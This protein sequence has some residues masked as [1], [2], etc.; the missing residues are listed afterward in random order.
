MPDGLAVASL[1]AVVAVLAGTA[2]ALSVVAALAPSGR[3][4]PSP[5]SAA[6]AAAGSIGILALGVIALAGGV[7][8]TASFGTVLGFPLVAVR[9]DALG[10]LFMIPLGIVGAAASV[11][12]IGYAAHGHPPDRTAAAYPVFLASLALVFASSDLIA[13]LLAWE[14]MAL[15]SAALVFGARPTADVA[16]AGY[17]YLALTHLAAGAVIVAFAMLAGAAGST[18][19]GSLGAAAASLPP[20]A[21]D[22][23]FVLLLVGFGTKAGA[24]P[25]HVWLPRAHPVAPSH[26]SALMSGVMVKAGIYGLVRFGFEVLGAGPDWWGVL[27]LVVGV[28][29]AVLGVLYALM[30]NDLKRLL[31]F[32]TIENIGIILIGLGIALLAAGRGVAVL[33]AVAL[34]AALVHVV[35]HALFKS[36]LFLAAGSVQAAAGTRDLNRLGGLA[37]LMPVTTIVFAIG[38]ASIAGL[39]PLNGFAGEW[40][41]FQ[42]LFGASGDAALSPTVRT[43]V[44]AA[45]GGL[46]LTTAL[47]VATFVKALGVGF[48]AL[49][50]SEGASLARETGRTMGAAMG[51]L[52]ACCVGLGLAAGPVTTFVATVAAGVL[53]ERG[54]VT[55]PAA[56]GLVGGL[57]GGPVYAAAPLA[58]VL[59][60]IAGAAWFAGIRGRPVRRVPT[61]TCGILPEAA[62]EYTSASFAKLILLYF[63]AILRPDRE[64]EVDL[65]PGTPFP[66]AIRYRGGSRH[67]LDERVYGPIHVAAVS[68]AQLARRLQGGSLQLYLAYTVTAVVLLLVLAR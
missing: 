9:L 53:G 17:T 60:L 44:L 12:A 38:A 26:V 13:F 41:T 18:D 46:G 66:R 37:R 48:L 1:A 34:T 52:V 16:R 59:V 3:A 50:R 20:I 7:P 58:V 29:S 33:G 27:V 40:L 21:R 30:E 64:L 22:A 47:A 67:V 49:P 23:V 24:I 14:V 43:I 65:H 36:A 8:L 15:S 6:L 61:W 5:L 10:G 35:N 68:V 28:V 42:A 51:L 56:P 54:A 55:T 19:I 57:V 4:N 25:L 11:Y 63:K 45:I 39:P 31:A 32:S 62:F 2:L